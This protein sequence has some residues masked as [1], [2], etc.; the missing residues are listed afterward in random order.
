MH[1]IYNLIPEKNPVNQTYSNQ[2]K[3]RLKALATENLPASVDLRGQMPAIIDQQ[4]V[5][6]CTACAV[7]AAYQFCDMSW[8]GSVLFLY[9]NTRMLDGT[10]QQ[11]A[12]ST[13]SQAINSIN[14]YGI[15]NTNLWPYLVN[16]WATQPNMNCYIEGLKHQTINYSH[17]EQTQDQMKACLAGGFPFV[18]GIYVYE[19]F[20]TDDVERTG[21]VPMPQSGEAVLGGHAVV[22][23]GYDDARQVWICRNSWGTSWGDAGYFTL[24]YAYLNDTNLAT[25]CWRITLVETDDTTPIVPV[26]PTPVPLIKRFKIVPKLKTQLLPSDVLLKD[27]LVD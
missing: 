11:D 5:G 9:Y 7:S 21:D 27:L 10:V 13:L 25:D 8:D 23:V 15:C 17:V 20:E 24:P 22:C 3:M 14:K 1:R 19:S 12:G 16:T 6:S 2:M 4:T 26:D 18:V